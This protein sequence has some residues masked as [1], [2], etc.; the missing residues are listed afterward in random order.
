M[1]RG[2]LAAVAVS[3]LALLLAP[4]AGAS[5]DPSGAPFGEDFVVGDFVSLDFVPFAPSSGVSGTIDAHSG[6][7]G[8]NPTG[9]VT[10][11]TRAGPFTSSVTCLTVTANRATIGVDFQPLLGAPPLGGGFLFVEDNDGADQDAFSN[12][13]TPTGEPPSVCPANP[14]TALS[15]N[16]GDDI[17]VHDAVPR[18][19]SKDQCKN[20][21]WRNFPGFKNQGECVASV[22]RRPQP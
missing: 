19:T 9:E 15:P 12:A 1:R 21:G 14:S 16:L 3:L 22:E 5:H 6:P 10:L 11:S 8:E 13:L 17:T 4:G 18:P 20:G 7:S 2:A